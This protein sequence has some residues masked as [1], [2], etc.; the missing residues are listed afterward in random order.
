MAAVALI[1]RIDKSLLLQLRQAV[2]LTGKILGQPFSGVFQARS[3]SGQS[4]IQ[5]LVS[6]HLTLLHPDFLSEVC[7]SLRQSDAGRNAV[8]FRFRQIIPVSAVVTVMDPDPQF[9]FLFQKPC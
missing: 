1:R 8:L 6:E 3:H 2:G 7:K 4:D 5:H 9:C